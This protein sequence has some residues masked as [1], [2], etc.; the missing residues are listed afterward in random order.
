ML[1]REYFIGVVYL[2]V[3]VAFALGITHRDLKSV[4]AVGA[5]TLVICAI[6]LPLVGILRDF[7]TDSVLDGI[8]SGVDYDATDSAIELAFENG[9]AEY[10]ASE[11]AV[12]RECVSVRADGFD[13][14]S[15]KAR[16][17][18][19]DLSGKGC[20]LDPKRVEEEVA[21]QFTDGGECEV[22]IR[23]G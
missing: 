16:R 18:Y 5:G 8:L 14:A 13:I 17:V 19:V 11:Y 20:L 7:D 22:A 12:S 1:L 10:V 23:L 6:L 21:R 3:F 2:L 9:I 15:L 4:T